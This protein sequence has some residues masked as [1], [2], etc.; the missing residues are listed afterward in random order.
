MKNAVW[1]SG[2]MDRKRGRK[3][4]AETFSRTG[5]TQGWRSHKRQPPGLKKQGRNAHIRL[6]QSIIF[7]S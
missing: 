2:K 3:E 1:K 5:K 6:T 7:H 4:P